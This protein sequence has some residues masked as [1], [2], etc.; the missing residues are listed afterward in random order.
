M[1]EKPRDDSIKAI[2]GENAGLMLKSA[3]QSK[4][5]WE[6]YEPGCWRLKPSP[7]HHPVER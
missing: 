5:E 4:A 3:L 2:Y 1:S 6:E 7:P